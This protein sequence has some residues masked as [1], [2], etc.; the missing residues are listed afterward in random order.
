MQALVN[1]HKTKK[2]VFRDNLFLMIAGRPFFT[3]I[4]LF[5]VW[6][7]YFVIEIDL[8]EGNIGW[9]TVGIVLF[10]IT[11]LAGWFWICKAV[12]WQRCWGKLIVTE[13][14]IIFRCFPL[15]P[16]RI[17]KTECNYIGIAD[18]R[19]YDREVTDGDKNDPDYYYIYTTCVAIYFSKEPYPKEYIGRVSQL[20][21]TKNFIK[22]T[23]SDELADAA[24]AWAPSKAAKVL[25]FKNRRQSLINAMERQKKAE[26]KRKKRKRNKVK[27]RKNR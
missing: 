15:R 20:Q 13:D 2:L 12:V 21:C 7:T 4:F 5:W 23:Y 9:V 17:R 22:F 8:A 27:H 3:S 19:K 16:K 1:D 18:Y 11:Q 6:F 24:F 14:E 10:C 26:K 25:G